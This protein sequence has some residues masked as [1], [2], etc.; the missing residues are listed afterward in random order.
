LTAQDYAAMAEVL[1][2]SAALIA[3]ALRTEH[4]IGPLTLNPAYECDYGPPIQY[5]ENADLVLMVFARP[6]WQDSSLIAW[7]KSCQRDQNHRPIS[8]FV[9]FKAKTDL[10]VGSVS[11]T[12]PPNA[13]LGSSI[14]GTAL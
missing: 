7:A 10:S 3:G 11:L 2:E 12:S 5:V 14:E 1:A 4:I 8:G 9:T 6:I 13:T